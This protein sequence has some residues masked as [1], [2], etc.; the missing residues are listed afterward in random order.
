MILKFK[1]FL[2]ENI[3]TTPTLLELE[4]ALRKSWNSETCYPGSKNDWKNSL[5]ELGQC[6]ITSLIVNDYFGG[7]IVFSKDYNHIWNI[8]PNGETVDLT[9]KQFGDIN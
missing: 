1:D 8:L 2:N 4:I 7:D 6:A 5:P 9:R 3:D